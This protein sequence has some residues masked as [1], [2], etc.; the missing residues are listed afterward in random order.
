MRSNVNTIEV[1]DYF[2]SIDCKTYI[3]KTYLRRLQ[4]WQDCSGAIFK[5]KTRV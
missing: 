5:S 4:I 2:L 3:I 1:P